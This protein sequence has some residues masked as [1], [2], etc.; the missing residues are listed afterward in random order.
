MLRARS[1]AADAT[2]VCPHCKATVLTRSSVCPGCGHHL[3][4]NASAAAE[5]KG[6]LAFQVEGALRHLNEKEAAEYCIVLTV[7]NA[8]GQRIARQVVNV[9][10]LKPAETR[11]VRVAV[12]MFPASKP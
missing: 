6:Y 5:A 10:G 4:F 7:E 8:A 3:R 9:G 11:T 2:R 1:E 12:E